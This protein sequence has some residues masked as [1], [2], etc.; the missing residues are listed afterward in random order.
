MSIITMDFPSGSIGVYNSD[1]TKMLDGLYTADGAA[2]V[3]LVNDPDPSIGSAGRV[4]LLRAS[5]STGGCQAFRRVLPSSLYTLG[6]GCRIWMPSLPSNPNLTMLLLDLRNGSNASICHLRLETDGRISA[7]RGGNGSAWT[8]GGTLLGTSSSPCFTSNAWQHV[9][10]KMFADAAAGTIEVRVNGVTYLS[11]TGQNTLGATGPC[12]QYASGGK[13]G[14]VGSDFIFYMK[15]MVVWDTT[16]SANNNFLGSVSVK[17]LIPNS[18][19]ALNW[20]LTGSAT[21]YGAVNEAPADDDT[22]YIYAVTPAPSADVMGLTDLPTDVTSVRALMIINRSKNTDGGDGKLQMGLVSG[23][24]TMLGADRQI[25][26]AYT[27]YT[28]ISEVDPATGAAWL[29]GAVNLVNLRY[30]RTL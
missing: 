10:V 17:E 12:T 29:P 25:T 11:L 26:T 28:D 19:V 27:Y 30:N 21:G 9:E 14:A 15:D 7:Y 3:S 22:K 5:Q 6:F 8:G 23:A 13:G 4:V 18:D 1:S 2:F 24:S 16:G 20:S